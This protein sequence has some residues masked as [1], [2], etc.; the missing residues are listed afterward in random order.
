MSLLIA[1]FIPCIVAVISVFLY[2]QFSRKKNFEL[3]H[4]FRIAFENSFDHM[5]LTD[6]NGIIQFAND[7]VTKVTGYSVLEVIG[8]TPALWGGQMTEE[9]YRDFWKII[10][11]DKKEY[12]GVIRNMRK[13]GELYIAEVR[14]IPILSKD[15]LLGFLGIERDVTPKNANTVL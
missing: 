15:K 7:S 10:K 14:I 13:S 8:K 3:I 4:K 5:I 2:A 9:F 6:E 1:I 11:V 12:V